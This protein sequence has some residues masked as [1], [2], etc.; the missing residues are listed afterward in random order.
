[1]SF[2][3]IFE[4]GNRSFDIYRHG[5]LMYLNFVFVC[6]TKADKDKEKNFDVL[7]DSRSRYIL[8][9]RSSFIF[10]F[11][12]NSSIYCFRIL[13][14]R[15]ARRQIRKAV[16]GAA[17]VSAKIPTETLAP[18][19]S[20]TQGDEIDDKKFV[21]VF[22]ADEGTVVDDNDDDDSVSKLSDGE[23]EQIGGGKTLQITSRPTYT[24]SETTVESIHGPP[25]IT[26]K[27]IR[28]IKVANDA[29]LNS[30]FATYEYCA[31][32]LGEI[33]RA[34]LAL[35]VLKVL[36][37]IDKLYQFSCCLISIKSLTKI[38]RDNQVLLFPK[39]QAKWMIE[40]A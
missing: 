21:P 8:L 26:L 3:V 13:A 20:R 29:H 11:V 4:C 7:P 16:N 28:P 37:I 2:R 17:A 19:T 40:E 6:R 22:K 1:M 9:V 31:M 32:K 24:A 18:V 36:S 14:R 15:I 27:P 12:R 10:N 23:R 5:R 38:H 30:L 35:E 33:E 34:R 39:I 25:S